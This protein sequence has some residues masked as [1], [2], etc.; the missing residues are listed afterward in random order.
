MGTGSKPRGRTVKS[1]GAPVTL[2]RR[3]VIDARIDQMAEGI[4]QDSRDGP[5][6]E[7]NC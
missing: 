3:V 1:T 6:P 4:P 5:D 2:V 7:G